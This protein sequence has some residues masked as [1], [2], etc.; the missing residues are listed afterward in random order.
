MQ[1]LLGV[2]IWAGG[3]VRGS[4]YVTDRTDGRP[5]GDNDE[6]IL[7]TVARHASKVIEEDWY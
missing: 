3:G 2:A 7:T 1:R 6:R 4:L 5:F